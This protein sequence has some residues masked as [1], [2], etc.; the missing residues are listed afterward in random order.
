LYCLASASAVRVNQPGAKIVRGKRQS[1]KYVT[2]PRII[3]GAQ[4]DWGFGE[5]QTRERSAKWADEVMRK[6]K[7]RLDD[8]STCEKIRTTIRSV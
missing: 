1:L 7:T 3:S 2:L 5:V 8:E 6:T 4:P